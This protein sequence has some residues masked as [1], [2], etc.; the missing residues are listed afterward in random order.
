M[1]FFLSSPSSGSIPSVEAY[2]HVPVIK[3]QRLTSKAHM[4]DPPRREAR[5]SRPYGDEPGARPRGRDPGIPPGAPR[6]PPAGARTPRRDPGSAAGMRGAGG[7]WGDSRGSDPR[8]GDPGWGGRDSGPRGA[9]GNGWDPGPPAGRGGD[10]GAGAQT[11]RMPA[12]PGRAGPPGRGQLGHGRRGRSRP[13]T[14]AGDAAD[15]DTARPA[16]Q[17]TGTRAAMT[18]PRGIRDGAARGPGGPR[19]SRGRRN[20]PRSRASGR[21]RR[22]GALQGGLGVCIIVASAA[23]GAILTMVARSAP[24]SLLGLFI[25][26]GTV[27]AAL[28]IRPRAGRMIFPVPVL[29]YLVAALISG[30]VFDRSADSSKTVLAIGAAQWI[31]SGFFAMALATVL[32]LVI[33]T[34][35][36]LLWRRGRSARRNPGWP[37]PPTGPAK[38]GPT[39][40]R[41]VQAGT[42]RDER[43]TMARD[44][45]A[46]RGHRGEAGRPQR[47]PGIPRASRVRAARGRAGRPAAL[48]VLGFLGRSGFGGP[49]VHGGPG[50]WGDPGSRGTGPRPGPRPGAEPYNFSSGA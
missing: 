9:G 15:R 8:G 22:W 47:N 32:A 12:Q 24:G 7:G 45:M 39:R 38:T 43:A 30:V 14:G 46:R 44:A 10:P 11:R 20:S 17:P 13:D 35:R 6:T 2:R 4:S 28:A 1:A 5:P 48:G 50:V 27:A 19:D 29:S 40:A 18:Q 31:A 49:R 3:T 16:T 42:G 25:V 33:I 41:T 36:W 34:A 26:A 23:I 21:P 37:V